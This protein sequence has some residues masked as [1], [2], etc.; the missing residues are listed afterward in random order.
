MKGAANQGGLKF[1]RGTGSAVALTRNTALIPTKAAL[2][3]RLMHRFFAL[4]QLHNRSLDP[5]LCKRIEA[6][7]E[8][9]IVVV[10]LPL[11]IVAPLT[12][13]LTAGS[14][15]SARLSVIDGCRGNGDDGST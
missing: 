15:G 13:W 12:H 5:F 6:L 4:R 9:R 1:Q 8:K 7:R 3:R 11:K 2:M 14:G 10:Y